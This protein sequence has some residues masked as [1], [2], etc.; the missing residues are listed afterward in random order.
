MS[1]ARTRWM[2]GTSQRAGGCRCWRV[3]GQP[4]AD[5]AATQPPGDLQGRSGWTSTTP[6]RPSPSRPAARAHRQRH[7]AQLR[8]PP[9]ARQGAAQFS[10]L[11]GAVY[12]NNGV[13]FC[14][15]QGG[16]PAEPGPSDT[17]ER[18][19]NG[20]GQIW[21]YTPRAQVLQL[22][23][24]SPQRG[25]ARLPRQRHHPPRA[26]HAG[27]VRGQH[28]RQLPQGSDPGWAAVRHRAQPTGQPNHRRSP[29][30]ATSS[31]VPHSIRT[32]TRSSSTSRPAAESRSPSGAPGRRSASDAPAGDGLCRPDR[33]RSG[34]VAEAGQGRRAI[35]IP[36]RTRGT[37]REGRPAAGAIATIPDSNS[38]GLDPPVLCGSLPGRLAISPA[39][40]ATSG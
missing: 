27:P 1:P 37:H 8:R 36:R 14:S 15:T 10:R 17:A 32:A 18:W 30:S 26:K 9:G 7:G 12:D 29:R 25:H 21:A 39:R 23:Y 22:I 33:R 2:S 28:Q 3:D 13:Y 31:P 38:H 24:Q 5:L 19:G 4:N 40:C 16:G 35:G 34:K 11:E 6:T 20:F